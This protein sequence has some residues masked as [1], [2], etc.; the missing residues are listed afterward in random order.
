MEWSKL[1]NIILLI[2]LITNLCLLAFV[3]HGELQDRQLQTQARENA[4]AFL[5]E[6][7][8]QVEESQVPRQMELLPQTVERDQEAEGNAAAALLGG[9]VLIEPRGGEVYR[10]YND[11]G[12]IQFHSDGSFQAEFV[13]G[14]FS[15]GEN[16]EQ[17]CLAVLQAMGFE[18]ELLEET[19]EALTFRQT[20]QGYPLFTR[21]A[22]LV[23]R[24]GS[25]RQ[26]TGG[27]RLTG[28]P[29][30]DASQTPITVATA[31]ISFSNGLNTLGD[32]C[33]R[34]DAITPGYVS[35]V[36][37]SGPMTLTPVWRITTDTGAYQLD[38]LTGKVSRV[39]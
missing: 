22:T 38:T 37:L 16:R 9:T 30:P 36:S 11:N 15:V 8:I 14:L 21:Q 6:M 10:Y 4:V 33:S 26:I 24:E 31:L 35:A 19:E 25:V 3:V 13:S 12:E 28:E 2:L 5:R 27:R 32:V 29:V 39:L 17:G 1:K 18:G 23:C 34:I 7:G 20:W